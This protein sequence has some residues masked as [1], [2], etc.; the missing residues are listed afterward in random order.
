MNNKAILYS[1][2][3]EE[4]QQHFQKEHTRTPRERE[5]ENKER[6]KTVYLACLIISTSSSFSFWVDLWEKNASEFLISRLSFT[7]VFITSSLLS[8]GTKWA[9][10]A[11]MLGD[12][13]VVAVLWV[14]V[15]VSRRVRKV[16]CDTKDE[17]RG[18]LMKSTVMCP[19]RG[20][21]ENPSVCL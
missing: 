6:D 11:L 2:Y 21:R 13:V 12:C 16:D 18:R 9:A 15:V 20:R 5:R 1:S 19:A 17:A 3:E 10:V 4:K 7:S 14:V 8:D